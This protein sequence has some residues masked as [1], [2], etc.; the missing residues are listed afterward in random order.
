V[1]LIEDDKMQRG[2]ATAKRDRLTIQRDR[3]LICI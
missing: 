2:G 1:L 3:W